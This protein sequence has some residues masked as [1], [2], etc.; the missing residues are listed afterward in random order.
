MVDD[1]FII[2]EVL[3]SASSIFL[4]LS[5]VSDHLRAL[6]VFHQ[7]ISGKILSYQP[8]ICLYRMV[9]GSDIGSSEE[10]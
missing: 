2:P 5:L 3:I 9:A 8:D 1:E 6:L 7:V 10:E 4:F